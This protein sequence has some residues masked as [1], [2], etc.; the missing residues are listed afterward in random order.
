L[1]ANPANESLRSE[2]L[3][4]ARNMTKAAADPASTDIE[5][6]MQSRPSASDA[7]AQH[8]S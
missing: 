4:D 5:F 6:I 2:L 3:N 8:T 7:K 1:F